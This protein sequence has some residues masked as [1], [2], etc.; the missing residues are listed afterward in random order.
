MKVKIIDRA[1]NTIRAYKENGVSTPALI[2]RILLC[3]LISFFMATIIEIGKLGF[4]QFFTSLNLADTWIDLMCITAIIS[5]VLVTVII[6]I[7]YKKDNSGKALKEVKITLISMVVTFVVAMLCVL[8]FKTVLIMPL[9]LSGLLIATLVS[10]RLGLV[11]NILINQAFYISFI[12]AFG[13]ESLYETSTALLT[14]IIGGTVLIMIIPKNSSRIRYL[15]MGFAVS[16]AMAV[17][18]II[19]STLHDYTNWESILIDGLWSLSSTFLS[20]AL[21]IVITPIFE[22][23]FN[24]ATNTR[25]AEIS[26]FNAPLLKRLSKE[27]PGTFSHSIM[28]ADLAELCAVAIGAN[29]VVA[30]ACGYYHD[31]GKLENPQLFIENQFDGVNP[32]DDFIPEVSVKLIT[33]HAMD[34]YRLIKEA[35]LPEVIAN[36]C[37]EHHGTTAVNYFF[38]KVK[39]I[40]ENTVNK[41]LFVYPGPKPQGKTAAIIMIVDTVEAAVRSKD[42][43]FDTKAE[44]KA[45]IHT[46]I[47]AKAE[48]GQFDECNLTMADLAKIEDTLTDAI[49]GMS[50]KRIK[51]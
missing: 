1:R 9:A 43:E 18:G 16:L 42:G 47:R 23:I 24:S 14:G 4:V 30:K 10:K 32:H 3:V 36:V 49:P 2:V 15:G 39:S 33:N 21:F 17:V 26:S 34:G 41:D 25:L 20:V 7:V 8:V 5:L 35:H 22:I 38:Y 51:Y 19:S 6:Y 12:L 29:A 13:E 50:H 31:I 44:L 37:V 46:L 27:A 40:T 45:F 28:V 11:I 48:E